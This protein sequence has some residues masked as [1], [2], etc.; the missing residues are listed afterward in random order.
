MVSI[1]IRAVSQY[2][3]TKAWVG[4][5]I[6]SFPASLGSHII[7][8]YILPLQSQEKQRRRVRGETRPT[9]CF[10]PPRRR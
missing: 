10:P 7:F 5:Y 4:G 2:R 3:A 1:S 9:S 6:I 8:L